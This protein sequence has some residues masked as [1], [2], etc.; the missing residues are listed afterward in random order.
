[1]YTKQ[2]IMHSTLQA[3]I[4]VGLQVRWVISAQDTIELA[5]VLKSHKW[6]VYQTVTL[7]MDSTCT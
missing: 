2:L 4:P 5:M 7:E 3:D 6:N 1:M